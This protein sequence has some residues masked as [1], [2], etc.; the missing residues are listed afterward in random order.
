VTGKGGYG[1]LLCAGEVV[2]GCLVRGMSG[3]AAVLA[4]SA[5]SVVGDVSGEGSIVRITMMMIMMIDGL[6]AP[7]GEV[8]GGTFWGERIDEK[9]M[10]CDEISEDG[11]KKKWNSLCED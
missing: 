10:E 5:A 8:S 4:A 7:P 11:F 9:T 1:R 3:D 6:E 2:R